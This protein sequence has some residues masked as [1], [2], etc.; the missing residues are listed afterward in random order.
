METVKNTLYYDE[1]ITREEY[2]NKEKRKLLVAFKLRVP[3][4]YHEKFKEVFPQI[5][6]L[7]RKQKEDVDNV[8]KYNFDIIPYDNRVGDV[9]AFH[10]NIICKIEQLEEVIEKIK[11]IVSTCKPKKTTSKSGMSVSCNCYPSQ[12]RGTWTTKN[13]RH[14]KY[15]VCILSYDRHNDKTGKTHKYLTEIKVHHYI[16]IDPSQEQKYKD[17]YDSEFCKL[18]ICPE[19]THGTERGGT[20]VRNYILRW[21]RDEGF[22][23][24]WMLDD[25]M[26]YKRLHMG[27]KNDIKSPEIFTHIEDYIDLYD[28]VGIASHNF[29]PFITE[30]NFR[31]CIATNSKCYSSLLLLT[32]EEYLFEDDYNEDVLLSIKYIQKGLTN[33][34]FNSVLY[35]KNTSGGDKGGNQTI[36]YKGGSQEGYKKK[37]EYLVNK[38][39]I[40]HNEGRLDLI[41]GKTPDDFIKNKG[42][43]TKDYHH[44]VFYEFMKNHKN[45]IYTKKE[46]YEELKSKQIREVEYIFNPR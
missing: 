45:N 24:V 20:P 12:K 40:L 1:S 25:N 42:L 30:N 2:K 36:I 3:Q 8:E 28:N 32:D 22:D 44:K 15:P 19:K 9:I 7:Q 10:T 6:F 13:H 46:N 5:V 4:E 27:Q 31:T 29:N 38:I 33:L 41:D 26:T 11:S 39:K 18:I 34:I 35:D 14:P 23:R 43:K 17:W 16:F 21:G 37:F